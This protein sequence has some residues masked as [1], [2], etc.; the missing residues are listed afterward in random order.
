MDR[1]IKNGGDARM[2]KKTALIL[3]LLILLTVIP[4]VKG[5]TIV[6]M[7]F[8]DYIIYSQTTTDSVSDTNNQYVRVST[9]VFSFGQDKYVSGL[10]LEVEDGGKSNTYVKLKVIYPDNSSAWTT[11]YHYFASYYRPS[12]VVP[13]TSPLVKKA[14]SV[15]VEVWAKRSCYGSAPSM[16]VKKVAVHTLNSPYQ[17][18]SSVSSIT[19]LPP[20]AD[21][22]AQ[23]FMLSKTEIILNETYTLNEGTIGFAI[24]WDGSN[25]V[26]VTD[27]IGID[28]QGYLYIKSSDNTYYWVD[29]LPQNQ[30]V[31]VIFSWSN[32]SMLGYITVE[33]N[34]VNLAWSGS[35]T[36]SKIGSIDQ[37]TGTII[38]SFVVWDTYMT[39][40]QA[41]YELQGVTYYLT[42]P[43]NET[44]VLKPEG[45][46]SLGTLDVSFLDNSFAVLS[47][48]VLSPTNT[49][50]QIPEN[51]TYIYIQRGSVE[52]LYLL[53][54]MSTDVP[55]VF[56]AE[57]DITLQLVT[58]GIYP[59]K[60]DTLEIRTLNNEI[61]FRSNIT[62]KSQE[63]FTA[64]YGKY[65]KFIVTSGNYTVES[66][67]QVNSDTLTLE[68]PEP[69]AAFLYT[70]PNERLEVDK[71]GN[72]VTVTYTAPEA[73]SAVFTITAFDSFNQVVFNTSEVIVSQG[74]T[75]QIAMTEDISYIKVS[76]ETPTYSASRVIQNK[77]DFSYLIPESIVPNGLRIIFFGS[78]GV[79]LV[80]RKNKEL[81]P[82]GG[83]IVL[84]LLNYIGLVQMPLELT[85][86]LG[87]GA[88]AGLITASEIEEVNWW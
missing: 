29:Q 45:G 64:L 80:A 19:Y 36:L 5:A 22:S 49:I 72:I 43:T 39:P 51:T 2:K 81:S 56:P 52:R 50:I 66:I 11:E 59:P 69:G 67:Y 23:G 58:L 75:R 84:E 70:T 77:L 46:T 9:I 65:Y 53:T 42:L 63:T 18:Y 60:Y 8:E 68:F 20:G 4:Q 25:N 27:S 83:F 14:S 62:G 7:D 88:A 28:D 57:R 32:S 10:T 40:E 54:N 12:I 37:D 61:A 86:I 13:F 48:G 24:K 38:D 31:H 1:G 3:S 33:D 15:T 17:I 79:F 55:L 76:I 78:L 74:F 34:Q 35:V 41:T 26:T 21:G 47:T 30:Y 82:L 44:L 73:T 6:S 85:A 87:V 71:N 16:V